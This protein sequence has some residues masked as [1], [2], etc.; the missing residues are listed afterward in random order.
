V[1][2]ALARAL[3]GLVRD[4]GGAGSFRHWAVH[5]GGPT[6]V[7][8]VADC[9][10]LPGDRLAASREVLRTA[11]NVSSATIF[12]VLQR[13]VREAAPGKGLALAFGPGLTAEALRFVLPGTEA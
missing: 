5:P 1:P 13:I 6:I 2:E 10:G 7:D 8:R 11:G 3:P 12:F 4:L 9:L